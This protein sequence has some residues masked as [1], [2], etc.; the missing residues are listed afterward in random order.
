MVIP[1]PAPTPVSSHEPLSRGDQ[2]GQHLIGLIIKDDGADRKGHHHIF[3]GSSGAVGGATLAANCCFVVLLIPE[4]EECGHARRRFKYDIAA[5]AAIAPVRP[6]ARHE[7]LAPKAACAVAAA[8]G[9]DTDTDFIDKH[10]STVL[11]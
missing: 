3:P 2:I 11:A 1:S 9:C 10:R 5:V 8:A 7:F 4:V 6:A